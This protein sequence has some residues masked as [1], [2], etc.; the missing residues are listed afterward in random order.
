MIVTVDFNISVTSC[1]VKVLIMG[2]FIVFSKHSRPIN[3]KI[4]HKKDKLMAMVSSS[5]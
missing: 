2:S 4:L 3:N 1:I 5:S